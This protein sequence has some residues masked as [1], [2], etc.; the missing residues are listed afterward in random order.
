MQISA[1]DN[2]FLNFYSSTKNQKAKQTNNLSQ[3]KNSIGMLNALS[4]KG[5]DQIPESQLCMLKIRQAINNSGT[6][7]FGLN[8]TFDIYKT[9]GKFKTNV[10]KSLVLD[11]LLKVGLGN[12]NN[13]IDFNDTLLTTEEILTYLRILSGARPIEQGA[14]AD[15]IE[16]NKTQLYEK[17]I[18][19]VVF[20]N[21]ENNPNLIETMGKMK[22]FLLKEYPDITSAKLKDILSYS[23]DILSCQKNDEYQPYLQDMY[24]TIAEKLVKDKNI[25]LYSI[26]LAI[27]SCTEDEFKKIFPLINEDNAQEIYKISETYYETK[28]KKYVNDFI[29]KYSK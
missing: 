9:L 11:R 29:K 5:N 12:K 2:N 4:F 13:C 18:D 27:E 15:V 6:M 3:N 8:D 22:K 25:P 1:I 23:F 7:R 28:R 21:L 10:K 16:H 14:I 19:S 26:E 17:D 24:K 20:E